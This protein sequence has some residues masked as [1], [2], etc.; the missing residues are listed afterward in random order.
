MKTKSEIQELLKTN[1][2]MVIKSLLKLY[3]YQTIEEREMK[4]VNQLNGVGFN[5]YDSEILSSI[6]EYYIKYGK[7]SLKQL[8][9]VRKRIMKYSGQILKIIE[10]EQIED[11]EFIVKYI[12]DE[13]IIQT[14][15]FRNH[16]EGIKWIENYNIEVFETNL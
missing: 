5:R 9:V 6:A 3:E 16:E 10:S 13:Y 7:V 14:K 12:D 15:Y 4:S 11:D 2:S 8:E 1:N